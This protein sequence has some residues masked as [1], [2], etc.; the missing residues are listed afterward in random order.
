LS[1]VHVARQ[2]Q[3][4]FDRR[5]YFVGVNYKFYKFNK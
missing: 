4:G 3:N 1:D 5:S 2:P